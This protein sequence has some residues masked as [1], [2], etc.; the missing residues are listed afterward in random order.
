MLKM[1]SFSLHA[2]LEAQAPLGNSIVDYPLVQAIPHFQ[3]ALLQIVYIMDCC[4]V[5]SVF[6]YARSTLYIP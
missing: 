1:S 6:H 4:L 2:S 3:Q 5:D